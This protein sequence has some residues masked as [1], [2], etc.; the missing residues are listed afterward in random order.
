MCYCATPRFA[1]C[2]LV[3]LVLTSLGRLPP[4]RQRRCPTC[5]AAMAENM[6]VWLTRSLVAARPGAALVSM[7]MKA[8]RVCAAPPADEAG[9]LSSRFDVV[10]VLT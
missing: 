3:L 9:V 4:S 8:A 1:V 7:M 10:L 5:V 6:Y 2:T